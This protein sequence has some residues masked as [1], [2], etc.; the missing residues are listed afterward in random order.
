MITNLYQNNQSVLGVEDSVKGNT[1]KF[2][3]DDERIGLSLSQ[4]LD[5]PE[6]IGRI[7]ASRNISMDEIYDFLNP[8]LRNLLPDPYLL[9]DMEKATKRIVDAI[10][11]KEKVAL[12][13]NPI[14]KDSSI[15][16][17][18]QNIKYDEIVLQSNG[19]SRI[20]TT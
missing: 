17:I 1:W 15:I 4:K 2:R 12:I 9:K 11:N 5:V 7:I 6:M 10:L 8:K 3:L 13:L 16:K 14:L 18:G 19:F 20:T